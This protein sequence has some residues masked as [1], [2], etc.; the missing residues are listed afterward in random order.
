LAGFRKPA[1]LQTKKSNQCD[2]SGKSPYFGRL[3]KAAQNMNKKLSLPIQRVASSRAKTCCGTLKKTT[4][5]VSPKNR[6]KKNPCF[7]AH[8]YARKNTNKKLS[9]P[10]QRVASSRAKTFCGTLKKQLVQSTRKI[11][12]KKARIFA[13]ILMRAKIRTKNSLFL[14]SAS[15]RAGQK[16][17]AGR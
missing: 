16:P 5:T 4:C 3:Q 10:I 11:G 12:R 14:F 15:L 13:R 7:C 2:S 8:S 9:L 17:V 1:N 6:E